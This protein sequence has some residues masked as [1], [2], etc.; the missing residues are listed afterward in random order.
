MENHTPLFRANSA[1][2]FGRG[3]GEGFT[4][5]LADKADTIGTVRPRVE[6]QSQR[7]LAAG[8]LALVEKLLLVI[9][10]LLY[11]LPQRPVRVQ[12]K[13]LLGGTHNLESLMSLNFFQ[14]VHD[15]R[16]CGGRCGGS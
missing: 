11:L 10:L 5:L 1:D 3:V 8:T 16:A 13:Y 4:T 6:D 9:P 2:E 12:R 14:R 7:L 15:M